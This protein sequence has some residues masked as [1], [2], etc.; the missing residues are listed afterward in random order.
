MSEYN[1]FSNRQPESTRRAQGRYEA[2]KPVKRKKKNKL[3]LLVSALLAV[4]LIV[5]I[6]LQMLPKNDSKLLG[7]WQYDEYTQYEFNEDGKGCLCADD[8]HYEYEYKVTNGK[9]EIDFTEDIVRDCNYT[10]V[11]EGNKLTL[12]GGEGTDGGT[13]EL[14]KVSK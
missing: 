4:I 13:Y 14:T 5:V 6:I 7:V 10:Y 9:L 8:V 11:V 3:L 12:T 1:E 2:R